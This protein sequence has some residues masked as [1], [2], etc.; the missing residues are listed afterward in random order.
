MPASRHSSTILMPTMDAPITVTERM[1]PA[2]SRSRSRL[3]SATVRMH[4]T[5]PP[6]LT[7]SGGTTGSAPVASRMASNSIRAPSA[8]T[9]ARLSLSR[10]VTR[11][12]MWRTGESLRATS[13][14]LPKGNSASKGSRP[15]A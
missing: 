2:S 8:R 11:V 7:P 9:R 10:A 13:S 3:A 1:P 14:R 15:A 12:S 5:R 4:S 6:T